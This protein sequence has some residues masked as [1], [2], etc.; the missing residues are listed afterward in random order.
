MEIRR[1][2]DFKIPIQRFLGTFHNQYLPGSVI[3]GR[4]RLEQS[5]V[6]YVV[7]NLILRRWRATNVDALFCRVSGAQAP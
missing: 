5:G 2:F 4:D 6:R 1:G 7:E 3:R